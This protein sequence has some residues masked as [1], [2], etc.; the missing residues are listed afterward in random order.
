MTTAM[1][2]ETLQNNNKIRLG[3][4]PKGEVIHRTPA[5]KAKGLVLVMLYLIKFKIII[6]NLNS[7]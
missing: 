6:Q 1:F 3:S 5:A 2:A 7:V 4:Y